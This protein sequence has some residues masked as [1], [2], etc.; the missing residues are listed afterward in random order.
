MATIKQKKA[1]DNLVENGGN[2]SKAMRDAGYS[3]ET[4]KDPSKLT[5]SKGFL[6]LC[7]QRG[8]TDDFLLDALVEDIE[9][10]PQN[11]KAELELA[12]K[13]KGKSGQDGN[14]YNLNIISEDAI[15]KVLKTRYGREIN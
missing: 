13:I 9:K 14:T 10:K 15:K 12:F 11:R 6:E 5:E 4:A 7:E 3:V 1:L 2:A 8:L